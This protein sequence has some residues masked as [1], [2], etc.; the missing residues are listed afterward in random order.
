MIRNYFKTAI[1][2]IRRNSTISILNITGMAIGLASSIL[3]LLWVQDEWSYNRHFKNADNLYRII[4]N[5]DPSGEVANFIV[6]TPGALTTTL[7]SEYPEIVRASRHT[8][9]PLTLKKGDEFIEEMVVSVD[10]DFL[11][12]FDVEFVQ[13]DINSAFDD[14]HNIVFTEKMAKKYFGTENAIGK[15]I[16]SR[17]YFITV[18]GVVKEFPD[19]S[20]IRFNF[21]VPIAWMKE[22][23]GPTDEWQARD[24]NYVELKRGTNPE[25]VE[26]KIKD[27]LQKHIDRSKSE[28][29]LQNIKKIHLFSSRQFTYDVPGH[30][31]I[32]YVRILSLVAIF[33]LIIACINFINL[34]TG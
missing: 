22:F 9:T 3:I 16:E 2:S 27:I 14:P 31:D 24:Y 33:I 32:T 34:S 30:G 15:K 12:M 6:P 13:G 10:E 5:Q 17:G 28:I 1:R 29:F 11:K 18:T 7:K 26:N 20:H 25:L 21:L 19:N 23:G 4:E 8:N